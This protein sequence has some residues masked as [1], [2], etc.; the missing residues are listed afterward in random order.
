MTKEGMD[1]IGMKD[2]EGGSERGRDKRRVGEK[3]KGEKETLEG[4]RMRGK[5]E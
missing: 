5:R 4:N 2:K 1:R 3:G